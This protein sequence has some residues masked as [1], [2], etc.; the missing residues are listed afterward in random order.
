MNSTYRNL[1]ERS[2]ITWTTLRSSEA[3][4]RITKICSNNRCDRINLK[5]RQDRNKLKSIIIGMEIKQRSQHLSRNRTSW[6]AR[7]LFPCNI[8]PAVWVVEVATSYVNRIVTG[9]SC[10][11]IIHK[12]SQMIFS[13]PTTI[14]LS[15]CI[16]CHAN[17]KWLCTVLCIICKCTSSLCMLITRASTNKSIIRIICLC[18]RPSRLARLPTD[19]TWSRS[20]LRIQLRTKEDSWTVPK[21]TKSRPP[22]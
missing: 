8:V 17:K 22:A 14:R 7:S 19:R 1:K 12:F 20:L 21:Q 2:K 3:L 16:K 10:R 9:K 13:L 11:K 6:R 15:K 5:D 18:P 4:L